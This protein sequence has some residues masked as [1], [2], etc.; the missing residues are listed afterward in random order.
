M[1]ATMWLLAAGCLA[2]AACWTA[3][4]ALADQLADRFDRSK[5]AIHR[6]LN[7]A[8]AEQRIAALEQ[9][10]DYPVAD[11]ARLIH[12]CFDDADEEVRAAAYSALVHT[13]SEQEVCDTLLEMAKSGM[14][15]RGG[16]HSVPLALAALLSSNLPRAQVTAVQFLDNSVAESP[17]GPHILVAIADSLGAHGKPANVR[18][19]ARLSNTKL[20]KRHF[21]V[22]RATV[23]ALTKIPSKEAVAALIGMM[24][25]A[26]GEARA[27]AAE[28]L[29]TVT[30]EDYGT[31]AEK[32]KSWWAE[33]GSAFEYPGSSPT[34][35]YRTIVREGESGKY[36]DLPLFAERLV[37]VLDISGSMQGGRMDAAKRE[38]LKAINGLPKHASF[39][40]VVFN[41]SVGSWKK[42]LVPAEPRMKRSAAEFVAQL[43]PQSQTATYDA[44]E[45]AFTFD[46][47]AI[48]FLTDGAPTAGKIMAPAD[49]IRSVTGV[50]KVRRISIY[51]IGVA[52]GF[53]GSVTDAFLKNLA[54]Q[55]F[56]HYRRIDG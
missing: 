1:R 24:T 25:E 10:R 32:W 27:D 44:L 6:Q 16:P 51:T 15:Q 17:Y 9:L 12:S 5:P 14:K 55:N 21:G 28:H 49:I 3:P 36:Y 38:L 45:A 52:P 47:E 22:R 46:T 35:P 37:F 40:V 23:G 41:G 2:H 7:S 33:A 8:R 13:N 42:K 11:A 34:A 53:P 39:G 26:G 31:N 29:T 43:N 30:G 50:N 56:G 19:L 48:Y 18:P 54:E 4:G 20:F